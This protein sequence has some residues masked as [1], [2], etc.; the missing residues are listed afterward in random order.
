MYGQRLRLLICALCALLHGTLIASL[1]L[2][3]S[4]SQAALTFIDPLLKLTLLPVILMFWERAALHEKRYDVFYKWLNIEIRLEHINRFIAIMFCLVLASPVTYTEVFENEIGAYIGLLHMVFTGLAI[5][6]IYLE[7]IRYYRTW[8]SGWWFNTII[9]NLAVANF[10][11]IFIERH[12]SVGWGETI[13]MVVAIMH[14]T[15]TK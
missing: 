15:K 10:V 9:I 11:T 6:G 8:S 1:G 14:Y 3:G 7:M 5:F 2:V 4:W 13:I 12:M